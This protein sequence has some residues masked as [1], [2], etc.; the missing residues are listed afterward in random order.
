M[1]HECGLT[2]GKLMCYEEE[3]ASQHNNTRRCHQ[4]CMT[5][6]SSVATRTQR[7]PTP[8][9][10]RHKESIRGLNRV[11][12]YLRRCSASHTLAHMKHQTLSILML[13]LV[14][15]YTKELSTILHQSNIPVYLYL[16]L[17]YSRQAID[18]WI[19]ANFSIKQKV[20]F[21]LNMDSFLF[22]ALTFVLSFHIYF[23]QGNGLPPTSQS[24][25]A[26]SSSKTYIIH[27]K[28]PEDKTL[29]LSEDVESWYLSFM[30]PTIMSSNEQPRMIYS[31]HNVMSGFAARLTKEELR[32][33]EKKNGFISARPEKILH[34]QTTHTP[35]F[36][37]LQQQTG[38]WKE[39]NF[40]KG[41]IIGVLD[42]GITPGHPS[43]NDAGIP[44]PPTK[45]KGR[46][47]LNGTACNNK[48]I[49]ARSFNVRSFNAAAMTVKGEK[50]E[51][52]IDEDGHGTHTASTAAGAFVDY[53]EV[54]GNARGTAAGIAPYAHLAIYKVCSGDDCPESDLLAA[55]DAAVEDGVDVISMS[56]GLSEPPP[57]FKD[58]IAIGAFAAIQK[59]IFVSCSAGNSG[60]FD[61]SLVNG[62][63]W[64]LTVGAS[65]TDRSIEATAKLGNGQEFNGE[66]VSQ[67]TDFPPTL[68][69]L[70][71]AG[72]NGKQESALCANGSL[73][74]IDFRGKVVLCERGGGM[75]RINKGK[76]VKRAGG[77]AMILIN[78]EVSGFSLLADAHVLPASHVSYAAGLQIKAYI[79]STATPT[80]TILFKGTIIGDSQSPAVASFSSRGPNLPS[81]GILK[82]DIIG[83]GVD[84]L[85]AWPFPLEN[86]TNSKL[87]F[88]LLSGTSMSCPHLSGVAALLK[89]SH[90]H[91]SPAAIK[92]A[93]MTSADVI[94]LEH[95]FIVDETLH[96]ADIFATGSGHVNPSRA[97]DPG[98]IY[99]IGPDDYIDYLCGLG[100]GDTDVGIIAHRTIKCSETSSIPEGELNYPSFSVVLGSTQ[101]FTRTVT[102]VGDVY[103]SYVVMVTPPEGVDVEV[104]PNKLDFSEANQKETYSVTFSR[105]G[106]G[107]VTGEYAQGFLQWV[108]AKHT[109]KS[110]ISVKQQKK[111]TERL[112]MGGPGQKLEA[113]RGRNTNSNRFDSSNIGDEAV[114]LVMPMEESMVA[115]AIPVAVAREMVM[116]A[117]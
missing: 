15:H 77:A 21:L 112:Q 89:S 36:L 22:I 14:Y 11:V 12:A 55:L 73:N 71:Y 92:S 87:T 39:S 72:K 23:T 78:D 107:N 83:P 93:I 113:L 48:L 20:K 19:Q 43:F 102:N 110:P 53:A 66:S 104:Q 6:D 88:N 111:K 84:I 90:P 38:L 101:T 109:V 32:A 2:L 82:P 74:D 35:E 30:P 10:T 63:P 7:R 33:L 103:S 86:N 59:G 27:V 79:N 31:Y 62:A 8:T 40:G 26:A 1:P 94:N 46:C 49:G 85:A 58:T 99:D 47:E 44:P 67:P 37:G 4:T 95:R 28:R 34:R 29:A 106:S 56:L 45:W 80:A 65:T 41:V 70:V 3:L 75:G 114:I 18:L 97:N 50:A 115:E 60:P 24:S 76:E 116:A 25:T 16:C 54:L 117:R 51:G 105:A 61:G 13:R 69:P 81:P 5:Q 17:A 91:W 57:F 64:I 98:L 68:L 42:S 96:P 9:S 52:P 108:S 100:Y